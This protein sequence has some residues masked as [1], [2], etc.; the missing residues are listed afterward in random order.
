MHHRDHAAALH[1]AAEWAGTSLDT[2]QLRALVAYADW[3]IEEAIPA[4]GLGP[5][6]AERII[7]RHVADSL[8]FGAGWNQSPATLIDV[9]SGVG[10]P[11]IPLAIAAPEISVTL[12]D[13][14]QRRT[15]LARRAIRIL[16][17]QGVSV[18]TGDADNH[19]QRYMAAVFRASHTTDR[20]LAAAGSLL[21]PNGVAMIGLRRGQG[22][23]PI[24]DAI[25]DTEIEILKTDEGVLD[26]TAWHLRMTVR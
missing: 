11:G 18:V 1:R 13:R 21:E 6:E 4:G 8:V 24:P 17:L 7:D 12:L 23:P 15:D 14:S 9:G 22:P 2:E 16:A 3:L 26:S 25:P 10:L 5:G 20:A 19:D